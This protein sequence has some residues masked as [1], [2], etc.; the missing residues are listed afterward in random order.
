MYMEGSREYEIH[1][2]EFCWVSGD[3]P[4][5][6]AP[7]STGRGR[8]PIWVPVPADSW[9]SATWDDS[10]DDLGPSNGSLYAARSDDGILP[11]GDQTEPQMHDYINNLPTFEFGRLPVLLKT[12]FPKSV[13][14]LDPFAE[15]QLVI[16][17][18]GACG[19][20]MTKDE[21][22]ELVSASGGPTFDSID[23]KCPQ[24]RGEWWKGVSLAPPFRF[25]PSMV[26][27]NDKHG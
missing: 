7:R 13:I 11:W 9:R 17:L 18:C 5:R 25:I 10:D 1:R 2:H 16:I 27:Y 8:P 20:L 24:C 21:A 6:M 4:F 19:V 12:R 26:F 15:N 3:A 22:H 23:P 14:D